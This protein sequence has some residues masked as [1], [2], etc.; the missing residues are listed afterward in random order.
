MKRR[1][2]GLFRELVALWWFKLTPAGRLL[3]GTGIILALSAAATVGSPG[4]VPLSILFVMGLLALCV[5]ALHRPRLEIKGEVPRRAV[6]RQPV[7]L[8]CSVANR[9]KRDAYDVSAGLFPPHARL[10]QRPAD[11]IPVVR[12]GGAVTL[13]VDL[14]A[15][16]RGVYPLP[17]LR[18]FTTFPLNIARNGR[19]G[20][21]M[22]ALLVQPAF[23]P[24]EEV[25]LSVSPR[26]QPGGVALTSNVGES[27]E[28]LGNRAFRTGDSLRHI[29]FRA[30]ARLAEPA[31][32]EYQE[33]YYCRVAMVVDSFLPRT[34]WPRRWKQGH[35]RFEA[36]I[37]LAASVADALS[38][39]EYLID[40]FAAGPELY[41]FR[42]GRHLAH[43]ENI[44]EILACL[45]PCR[46]NPFQVLGP[47]L[48]RE[49]SRISAMVCIFLDWDA[50][51]RDLVRR[52]VESGCT[53]KVLVVREGET[54]APPGD[55]LGN[56]EFV[57]MA[58]GDVVEGTLGTL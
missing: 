53:V 21:G 25:R 43:L 26:Y 55:S 20:K 11:S 30:W 18:A 33:E 56:V 4:Y 42:A 10:R 45:D 14:E 9:G 46:A 38:R 58:P 49:L 27:P 23:H 28:Y 7:T 17:R 44:L 8:T 15:K 41:V 51:R 24:L 29:D 35:E 2:I 1:R 6:A 52:A 19:A 13:R 47:H 3:M 32:R 31:V 57:Q 54:T 39:G 34:P 37:S 40:V 36:G 48:M 50:P 5:N 22:G 12:A 16:R